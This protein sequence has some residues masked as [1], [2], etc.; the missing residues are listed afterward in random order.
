[1]KYRCGKCEHEWEEDD[2]PTICPSCESD[3]IEEVPTEDKLT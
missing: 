3:E 2:L 1:M